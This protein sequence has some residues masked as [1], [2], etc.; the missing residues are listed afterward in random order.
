MKAKD[1][2]ALWDGWDSPDLFTVYET[3]AT[4]KLIARHDMTGVEFME[5]P[6][7]QRHIKRFGSQGKGV[8]GVWRHYVQIAADV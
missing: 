5:S 3:S 7:A 6:L 8:D 4:G 1:V 2:L